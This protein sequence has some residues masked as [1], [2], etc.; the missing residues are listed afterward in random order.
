MGEKV[1]KSCM[2]I[3]VYD[4]ENKASIRNKVK[5]IPLVPKVKVTKN[6]KFQSNIRASMK[7]NS[8]RDL[9]DDRWKSVTTLMQGESVQIKLNQ[10]ACKEL[11]DHKIQKLLEYRK[12]AE[13]RYSSKQD[14]GGCQTEE[15]ISERNEI[16]ANLEFQR[17]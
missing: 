12:E 13:K 5:A 9:N 8:L 1:K 17:M 6:Q 16:M 14:T 10:A 11:H 3:D 7:R 15:E 2:K 4:D